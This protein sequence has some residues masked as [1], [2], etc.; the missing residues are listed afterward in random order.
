MSIWQF[1]TMRLT[2]APEEIASTT[3]KAWDAL[4]STYGFGPFHPIEGRGVILANFERMSRSDV[5]RI[6]EAMVERGFAIAP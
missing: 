5:N 2:S 6:M 4:F 1:N 3:R